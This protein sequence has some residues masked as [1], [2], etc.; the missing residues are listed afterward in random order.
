MF[1]FDVLYGRQFKFIYTFFL[2]VLVLNFIDGQAP[3]DNQL[4]V[5]VL[6]HLLEI[7]K[8]A[9]QMHSLSHQ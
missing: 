8:R 7:I 1:V 3:A 2:V 6:K 5:A 4:S 9:H